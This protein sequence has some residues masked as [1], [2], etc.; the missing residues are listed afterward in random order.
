MERS[1]R[2]SL[3]DRHQIADCDRKLYYQEELIAEAQRSLKS[4]YK[5]NIFLGKN[6]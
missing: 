6:P 5:C 4:I 1:E 3:Y 2:L